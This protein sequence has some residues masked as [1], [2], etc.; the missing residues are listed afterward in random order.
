MQKKGE[1]TT[2]KKTYRLSAVEIVWDKDEDI[3]KEMKTYGT[4]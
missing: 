1:R 4:M 2:E 3:E